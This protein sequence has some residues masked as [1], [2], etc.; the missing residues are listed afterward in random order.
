MKSARSCARTIV[1]C[2]V[3]HNI[4]MDVGDAVRVDDDATDVF[5]GQHFRVISQIDSQSAKLR[6]SSVI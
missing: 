1:A 3:L 4:T 5:F 2:M 6:L